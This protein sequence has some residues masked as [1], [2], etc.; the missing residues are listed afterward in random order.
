MPR[1]AAAP[2]KIAAKILAAHESGH[3]GTLDL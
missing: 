1:S 3:S 2:E